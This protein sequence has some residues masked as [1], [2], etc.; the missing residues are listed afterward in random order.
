MA[1]NLRETIREIAMTRDEWDL[2]AL[3]NATHVA[4]PRD[5]IDAAYR[6]ALR[7]IVRVELGNA[8]TSR[9]GH[10]AIDTHAANAG[11]GHNHAGSRTALARAGF[12]RQIHAAS[13]TW[14][15]LLSCT[16][17]ELTYA[18]EECE[19][20]AS[21]NAASAERYRRLVKLMIE[22]G[23]AIVA[24]LPESAIAEVFS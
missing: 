11:A 18:A 17:D 2:S 3:V 16:A 15:S 14:K 19:R 1:F 4:T 20:M 5:E 21:A 8:K 6:E 22:H 9:P 12:R 7:E 24:E 10:R 13:D 23:A